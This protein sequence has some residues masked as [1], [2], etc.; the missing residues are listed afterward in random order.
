MPADMAKQTRFVD[1]SHRMTTDDQGSPRKASKGFPSSPG[2]QNHFAQLS[3]PSYGNSAA[4]LLESQ[5]KSTETTNTGRQS[6][7]RPTISTYRLSSNNVAQPS[8][9]LSPMPTSPPYTAGHSGAQFYSP[10]IHQHRQLEP[11]TPKSDSDSSS[12]VFNPYSFN[13]GHSSQAFQSQDSQ[14]DTAAQNRL[15][16]DLYSYP[17][18]YEHTLI[19]SG[20]RLASPFGSPASSPTTRSFLPTSL[21]DESNDIVVRGLQISDTARR[22]ETENYADDEDSSDENYSTRQAYITPRKDRENE[23]HC[24]AFAKTSPFDPFVADGYDKRT[25]S[26]GLSID[27]PKAS[28]YVQEG[29][30]QIDAEVM[31]DSARRCSGAFDGASEGEESRTTATESEKQLFCGSSRYLL[32]GGL[33]PEIGED[34]LADAIT[35]K[36]DIYTLVGKHLPAHGIAIVIFHDHRAAGLIYQAIQCGALELSKEADRV[37]VK[38]LQA[39]EC[40]KILG[41]A[42]RPCL[43]NNEAK[44]C[45]TLTSAANLIF[46]PVEPLKRT[47]STLGDL[48]EFRA[49]SS[50]ENAFLATFCD[51][52]IGP[53][54]VERLHKKFIGNAQL[55]LTLTDFVTESN[56]G[57]ET[58]PL[59]QTDIDCRHLAKHFATVNPTS[60]FEPDVFKTQTWIGL[61]STESPSKSAG[62]SPLRV[63]FAISSDDRPFRQVSTSSLLDFPN[64]W[65]ET[66]VFDS[67]F[68]TPTKTMAS[69]SAG[70]HDD[71]SGLSSFTTSPGEKLSSSSDMRPTNLTLI[72]QLNAKFARLHSIE[73]DTT[74]QHD[75]KWVDEGNVKPFGPALP[76]HRLLLE[77]TSLPVTPRKSLPKELNS[78]QP[79]ALS[80]L[81]SSPLCQPT[82][83]S[84]SL[85]TTPKYVAHLGQQARQIEIMKNV[86]REM[87]IN[88]HELR[89][90]SD[91]RTS[92]MIKDIP[93]KLSRQQLIDCIQEVVPGEIDFVYLRFDFVNQCNVAYAFVNFTSGK[94]P[95][96][97]GPVGICTYPFRALS[98]IVSFRFV[99]FRQSKTWAKVEHLLQRKGS[100]VSNFRRLEAI[101]RTDKASSSHPRGKDAFVAHFVHSPIMMCEEK[102]RPVLLDEQGEIVSQSYFRKAKPY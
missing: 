93:N 60:S 23:G 26:A 100:S 5:S 84:Y 29:V 66:T 24:Q 63:P 39:Q 10:S 71:I 19:P 74:L 2:L 75:L 52:R 76:S 54:A 62:L 61:S 11:V 99:S 92:V 69:R 90:G 68:D 47:L 65:N 98:G 9:I 14:N 28:G 27:L 89:T 3:S 72:E 101:A 78:P 44:V 38:F 32:I 13:I 48:Q 34:E 40:H 102:W 33:G 73:E 30:Q 1:F 55:R 88:L 58:A 79:F 70:R 46:P 43:F 21:L 86:P 31:D 36:A 50:S 91:P 53:V 22:V 83:Q 51:S 59:A 80:P 18:S 45:I 95:L 94:F 17:S 82:R 57:T 56:P 12:D 7:I 4:K 20:L 42:I 81:G 25:L 96:P 35:K 16:P 41:E 87:M 77:S 85:N 67:T 6:T 97:D 64:K 49:I 37:Y 8:S 15:D